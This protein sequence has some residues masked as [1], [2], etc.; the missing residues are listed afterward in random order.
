MNAKAAEK[1][2]FNFEAS[3]S[4]PIPETLGRAPRSNELP[5]R[6]LFDRYEADANEG[7]QPHVFI[8]HAYW[9]M[10]RDVAA[11]KVTDSYVKTKIRDQFNA[12]KKLAKGR[13]AITLVTLGR[14]G[15]EGIKE[16]PEAGV[17]FWLTKAK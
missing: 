16:A 2:S 11:D 1:R 6:G 9:V 17:S 3:F 7:K 12:W 5:F 14:T 10:E 4:T 15:K 13:E 8:P